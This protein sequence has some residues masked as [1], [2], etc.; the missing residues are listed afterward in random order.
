MTCCGFAT[1]DYM[2]FCEVWLAGRVITWHSVWS[3]IGRSWFV[4]VVVPIQGELLMFHTQTVGWLWTAGDGIVC[5]SSR[6]LSTSVGRNLVLTLKISTLGTVYCE[7][8]TIEW[9][10]LVNV[11]NKTLIT[12]FLNPSNFPMLFSY[13]TLLS[14]VQNMIITW[15]IT[16]STL[17][18]S[19]VINAV[20]ELMSEQCKKLVWL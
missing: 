15:E 20:F 1:R 18:N 3:V 19:E 6:F 17:A 12:L 4:C 10:R 16:D 9:H 2:T 5:V 13:F 7:Q 14:V 11:A 8:I